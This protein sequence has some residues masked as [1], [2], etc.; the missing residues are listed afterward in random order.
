LPQGAAL[1]KFA[2]AKGPVYVL[3][4]GQ[5]TLALGG[6]Y[7]LTGNGGT[8]INPFSASATL[9]SAFTVTN[10]NSLTTINRANPLTINWTGAGF[11]LVV[12]TASAST[13]ANSTTNHVYVTCPVAF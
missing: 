5:G 7:T 3:Q 12:I 10:W 9:P 8:Q 11:D 4:P 13:T 6:T 2:I 1:A